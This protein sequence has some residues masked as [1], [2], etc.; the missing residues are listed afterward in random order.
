MFA[1][2]LSL[3]SV[4][5]EGADDSLE[6]WLKKSQGAADPGCSTL[7]AWVTTWNHRIQGWSEDHED[8]DEE[9]EGTEKDHD[10][11]YDSDQSSATV[12]SSQSDRR[13]FCVRWVWSGFSCWDQLDPTYSTLCH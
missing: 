13:S 5:K 10:S 12:T 11:N 6:A 2:V 3:S 7:E 1:P 9:E 4:K 8:H